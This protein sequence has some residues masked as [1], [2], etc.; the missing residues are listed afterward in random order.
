MSARQTGSGYKESPRPCQAPNRIGGRDVRLPP[1]RRHKDRFAFR[2]II[3]IRVRTRLLGRRRQ[4]LHSPAHLHA[5]IATHRVML[6]RPWRCTKSKAAIC[7]ARVHAVNGSLG[8]QHAA[9][10][11]GVKCSD[12]TAPCPCA[13]GLCK[14]SRPRSAPVSPIAPWPPPAMPFQTGR[15]H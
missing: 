15:C 5:P 13:L 6:S 8:C 2:P 1:N 4:D 9:P 7:D 11:P 3:L 14:C 10:V 12:I